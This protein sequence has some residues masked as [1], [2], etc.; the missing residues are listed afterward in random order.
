MDTTIMIS[1]LDKTHIVRVIV[2]QLNANLTILMNAAK[3]AHDAATHEENI[4]DNKYDTLSLEASYV[5]QGQANRAQDLR[6]AIDAYH[7]LAIRR[8]DEDSVMGLTALAVLEAQDGSQMTVFLG[9]HAGG[10]TVEANGREVIVITP[11][12]PLGKGLLGKVRGDMVELRVDE[13]VRELEIIE[14]C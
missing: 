5:A 3:A 8:F 7:Q 6:F 12:S 10:L 11:S 4:A 2:E 1:G 9:P 13:V 14:V